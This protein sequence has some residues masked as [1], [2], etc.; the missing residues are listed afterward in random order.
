MKH[1]VTMLCLVILA[2]CSTTVPVKT[3]FP[4]P[5]GELAQYSCPDLRKLPEKPTLSEVARSVTE[6]YQ[7]YYE[8]AIRADAWNDWYAR[9]KRIHDSVGKNN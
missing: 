9:Q 6:N 1:T 2:G 5:P 7:L 3:S 4:E 8:C